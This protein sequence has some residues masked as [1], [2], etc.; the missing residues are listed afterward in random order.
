MFTALPG[1]G[2]GGGGFR[3]KP[4]CFG[5]VAAVASASQV[6]VC[7]RVS[8]TLGPSRSPEEQGWKQ[9]WESG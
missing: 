1:G 3:E 9:T 8:P 2:G 5:E 4:A 7:M 6:C